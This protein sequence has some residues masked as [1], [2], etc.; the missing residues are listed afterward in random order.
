MPFNGYAAR[1]C[2][3]ERS[4]VRVGRALRI[5]PWTGCGA[6]QVT[7]GE[8]YDPES[9]KAKRRL[10]EPILRRMSSQASRGGRGNQSLECVEYAAPAGLSEPCRVF[11]QEQ[12]HALMPHVPRPACA[13]EPF[14]GGLRQALFG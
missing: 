5:V 14:R 10:A 2:G 1:R 9:G 4:T 3:V 12:R 11:P 7:R 6:R 8:G 13:S